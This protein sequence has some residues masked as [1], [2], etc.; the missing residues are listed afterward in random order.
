MTT[1]DETR[2]R[3][4]VIQAGKDAN[5]SALQIAALV[6]LSEKMVELLGSVRAEAVG[7]T[8]THARNQRDRGMDHHRQPMPE[9]LKMAAADLN[10]ERD[11]G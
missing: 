2:T 10:P 4:L 11:D 9:L 8:W 1:W 5:F 6:P 7:W 3:E